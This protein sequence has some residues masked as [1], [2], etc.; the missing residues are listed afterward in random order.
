MF[1]NARKYNFQLYISL[2]FNHIKMR[3]LY[4]NSVKQNYK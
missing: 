4:Q 3:K 1:Q 2:V